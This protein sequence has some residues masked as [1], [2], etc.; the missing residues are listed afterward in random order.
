MFICESVVSLME[1]IYAFP[2]GCTVFDDDEGTMLF[3]LNVLQF[4]LLG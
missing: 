4:M 2:D 3:G 1:G